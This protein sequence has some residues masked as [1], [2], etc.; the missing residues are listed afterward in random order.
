M[1][2]KSLTLNAFL[3]SIRTLVN[4]IFPLITYPYIVRV[5]SV[6][7]IGRINFGQS[8]VSYFTLLAGLGINT[9]AIRNGAQIRDSKEKINEFSR[10]VFTINVISTSIS[11]ALLIAIIFLPTKIAAYRGIIIIQGI[12]VAMSPLAVDWLYTIYE[13]FGYITIRSI[14]VQ[15]LSLVLMF[16]FVKKESDVYLYVALISLS[17][18]LGNIF[19]YAHSKKYVRL[20]LTIDT[21]WSDYKK[22]IMLFFLNSIASV[23]YINS[24]VTILGIIKDDYSVGLYSVAVKIYSIIKQVFNAVVDTTIPRLAYLNNRNNDEF[25]KLT[26]KMLSFVI[27]GVFPAA[28]GI[29]ILRKEIIYLIAGS[30]Y[31]EAGN[32]LVIL[33]GAILFAILAN[34]L[35]NGVLISVGRENCVVKATILSAVGNIVLNII[36][37]PI[38]SQNGAAITTLFAEMTVFGMS[39]YYSRDITIKLFDKIEIRNA[40]LGSIIMFLVSIPIMNCLECYNFLIRILVVVFVCALTYSGVLF[41]L[42]DKVAYFIYNNVKNRLCKKG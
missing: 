29:V 17:T 12:T 3:S 37:I 40:M 7:N 10:R 25:K 23:I 33:S 11:C 28:M 4:I 22:I 21:H 30:S 6:E 34:I 9:F 42:K 18:S 31:Y 24:D 38:L 19:N 39:L 32:T 8:I 35:A 20:R 2:K 15:I 36:F 1:K 27:I 26:N 16:L 5:L 14:C 41:L 13:D